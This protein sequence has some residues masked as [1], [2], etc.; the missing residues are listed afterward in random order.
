MFGRDWSPRYV[1]QNSTVPVRRRR[2]RN[3]G[4]AAA[5]G[6]L[7]AGIVASPAV[8]VGGQVQLTTILDSADSWSAIVGT[9]PALTTP[10]TYDVFAAT[11]DGVTPVA[12]AVAEPSVGFLTSISLDDGV[13]KISASAPGF[14]T[15]WF[16]STAGATTDNW[17]ELMGSQQRQD[18]ATAD[19]I[20]VDT[21]TG[22]S[23]WNS[24]GWIVLHE[25]A[26]SISGVVLTDFAFSPGSFLPG[27]SVELYD[28]TSPQSPPVTTVASDANGYY[29]FNDPAPGSYQVRF[30]NGGVSQW[31]PETTHRAEA[32]VIVLAAGTNY[33]PAYGVFLATPTPVDPLRVLTLSGNPAPGATLTAVPD[34]VNTGGI[35]E[36][37]GSPR[38]CTQRYTWLVDEVPDP[39]AFGATFII[40]TSAIGK[41][42]T[43]RLDIVSVGCGYTTLLSNSIGPIV[44]GATPTGGNVTVLLADPFGSSDI[45]LNFGSVTSAGTTSVTTPVNP[46]T[47][48]GFSVL[49]DPPLIYDISTTASVSFPVELCISFNTAGMTAEQ[50]S[51]QSLFHYEGGVWVDITTSQG[52]GSVC[53]LTNS[54]SPFAVG[55]PWWPFEGFKRP[56]DNGGT[57]NV[58]KS[59]AAVPI[60]FSLGGFRGLDILAS[61]AP[62]SASVPCSST[63]SVD[64]IE[65]TV[66]AGNSSLGYDQASDTYS[67][68][69]KTQKAWAGTCRQ[70]VMT[71]TDGS[72][73]RALFKFTK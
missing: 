58:M 50:A 29:S 67:Y 1:P 47:P 25:S 55:Q 35:T 27:V 24:T 16:S 20:T 73:H 2:L 15:S 62:A 17:W 28:A 6:L 32:E 40:P 53:G 37:D 5:L 22:A 70:F 41:D 52:P 61:G 36:P 56:V 49:T 72:V 45:T 42:I 18:F 59:G 31:W 46:P 9:G 10:V 54:F 14:V 13:Y 63:A 68:I 30:V 69:W 44:S 19:P 60:M 21:V 65:L 43:A 71:L 34:Y 38:A 48:V 39:D 7:A 23:S 4:L 57:F 3:V 51:H 33:T 11:G 64:A 26:T 8:A 66:T 12:T